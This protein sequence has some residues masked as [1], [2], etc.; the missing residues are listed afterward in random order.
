MNRYDLP[1]DVVMKRY[2]DANITVLSTEE[3]GQ[4]KLSWLQSSHSS[5]MHIST[6][7]GSEF[8]PWYRQRWYGVN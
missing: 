2:H 7:R 5:M 4:I 3:V 8:D 6:V 1:N